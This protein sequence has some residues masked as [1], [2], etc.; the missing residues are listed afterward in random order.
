MCKPEYDY[1]VTLEGGQ[2]K[3]LTVIGPYPVETA[4]EK[5]AHYCK[6]GRLATIYRSVPIE[7]FAAETIPVV[8]VVMR[9]CLG[10]KTKEPW[11]PPAQSVGKGGGPND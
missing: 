2:Y 5:A 9:E 1:F 4:R 8:P 11:S 10:S 7:R 3:T 6:D